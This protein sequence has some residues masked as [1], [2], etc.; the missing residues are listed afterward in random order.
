MNRFYI[1]FTGICLLTGCFR[2]PSAVEA[3]LRFADNN[4]EELEKV[5]E[6][7][8][9]FPADSLKYR[10]ACFLIENMLPY[11]GYEGAAVDTVRKVLTAAL[12]LD[13]RL[14]DEALIRAAR[15][16]SYDSLNK[17]HDLHVITAGYLIE[18]IE[19]A[20]EQWNKRPWNRNLSFEDF[21]EYLLPYRIRNEPLEN[22]RK[23]YL[24]KY[25]KVLDSL[26]TGS[27]PVEA[28]NV[29]NR[30]V[31]ETERVAF[32]HKELKTLSP[33]ALY[34]LEYKC[35]SCIDI[36]DASLYMLRACGIPAVCHYY[37]CSPNLSG[38]HSWATIRDT[39]GL[40]IPFIAPGWEVGRDIGI[41]FR[42]GKV[43]RITYGSHPEHTPAPMNDEEALPSFRNPFMSD[44]SALYTGNNEI[45]AHV[46]G[47]GRYVYLGVQTGKR[48][49]P[50]GITKSE[51]GIAVFKN[52]EEGLVYQ[53]FFIENQLLKP[54]GYPVMLRDGKTHAFIPD[55][56]DREK[57]TLYRK[58][59]LSDLIYES[60]NYMVGG[61]LEGSPDAGFS[62]TVFRH[63]ITDSV[64][65]IIRQ[66]VY[67]PKGFPLRYVRFTAAKNRRIDI[68]GV[69]LYAA[70]DTA[71]VI[72]DISISVPKSA[73]KGIF[74]ESLTDGD[75]LTYYMSIDSGVSF[76]LDMGALR[77]IH[78]IELTPHTDDN[79]ISPGEVYELYYHAGTEGWISLGRQTAAGLFLE[80]ENVPAGALLW[81]Q[82]LSRG[83]EEQVFYMKN[84]RQ[85]FS[86]RSETF[87]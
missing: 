29:L 43:Y 7:Y 50:I 10:A 74:P 15:E 28:A 85:I 21:C 51:D 4:R 70:D 77:H 69:E 36:K 16:F 20:F 72:K 47:K 75:P 1:I 3:S 31:R 63:R 59:G 24:D 9:T 48:T 42:K 68:S 45:R 34:F 14:Y 22:W 80:Y 56:N 17:V 71:K 61:V 84:G 35:G 57:Q 13:G 73:Y 67:P 52:V 33:G 8:S 83:Q 60:M 49:T 78:R 64:R 54:A 23:A 55:M 25:A 39:T 2:Y 58:Y 53:L 46:S 82:N 26:Y 19:M 41:D 32:N 66:T 11:Y 81:L 79:F 38:M 76:T 62:S 86:G 5:L 30:Y 65:D 37:I 27:D 6:H 12:E 18:N 44:V 87:Y 40:D